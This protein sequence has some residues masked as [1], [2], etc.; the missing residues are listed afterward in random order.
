MDDF[1][2]NRDG[3]EAE[4]ALDAIR[5]AAGEDANVMPTLVDGALARCTLG[6]MVQAMADVYGRYT[7]GPEW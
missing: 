5:K 3:G 2:R 4:R 7:S 1:R 6:E